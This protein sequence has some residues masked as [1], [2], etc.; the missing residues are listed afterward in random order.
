MFFHILE[1]GLHVSTQNINFGKSTAANFG[2]DN[3]KL[4]AGD[5]HLRYHWY[6]CP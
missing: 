1:T 3:N 5:K 6:R 2:L 4:V